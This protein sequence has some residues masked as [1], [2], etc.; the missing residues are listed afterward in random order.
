MLGVVKYLR[1]VMR[2]SMGGGTVPVLLVVAVI[3]ACGFVYSKRAQRA[4]EACHTADLEAMIAAQNATMPAF[5]N[6]SSRARS[7]RRSPR[8]GRA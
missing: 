2:A 8:A 6:N 1:I 3:A 4:R 5:R 7:A